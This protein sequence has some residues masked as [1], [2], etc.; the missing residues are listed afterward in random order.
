M[1]V[2][3]SVGLALVLW[4]A[5]FVSLKRYYKNRPTP[6][7][8]VFRRLLKQGNWSALRTFIYRQ[9]RKQTSQLEMNKAQLGKSNGQKRWVEDSEAL[10]QGRED[11]NVFTRLWRELRSL[12]S[13][14]T[15]SR[16]SRS[17]FARLKIPKGLPDLKDRTK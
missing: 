5:L 2:F 8:L 16:H 15:D 11:K 12:P 1:S 17:I 13:T 10:Q 3:I 7:W 6:S 4:V 9:L 14:Q